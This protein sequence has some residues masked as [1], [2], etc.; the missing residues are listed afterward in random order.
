MA[1]GVK[2]LTIKEG[3]IDFSRFQDSLI[4]SL[5]SQINSEQLNIQREK[6]KAALKRMK[7]E[8]EYHSG[9]ARTRGYEPTGRKHE[10]IINKEEAE[11]VKEIFKLYNSGWTLSDVTQHINEK[12]AHLF[13]K[14]CHRQIFRRII[15]NPAYC[16]YMLNSDGELIKCKPLQG[17]EIITLDEWMTAQRKI[18]VNRVYKSRPKSRWLPLSPLLFCGVCGSKISVHGG[19]EGS[20]PFYGYFRHLRDGGKPCQ[21]NLT[22]SNDVQ[23]GIGINEAIKPLLLAEA[24]HLMKAAKNESAER[25]KL[26]EVELALNEI[27]KKSKKLT[28]MWMNSL[29]NED[30][31]ESAIKDLKQRENELSRKQR[32]LELEL[33]QDT[34]QFDWAKL[35]MKF[36]GDALT[37]GEYEALTNRMIKKILVYQDHLEV[38]TIYGDV[39]IPRQHVGRYRLVCN[40]A[41]EM[42]NGKAAVYFYKGKAI[43]HSKDVLYSRTAI[44]NEV[45]IFI[46]E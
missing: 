17:K 28:E 29:M 24:L 6:V 36:R 35:M 43:H 31:Y 37:N 14:P 13:I 41:L 26:A 15:L 18:D 10:V 30:V 20:H 16:G 39:E 46:E 19:Q 22:V 3:I 33:N 38:K 44:L 8:G 1:H 23:E 45:D 11:M 9:I 5:T 25:A 42:K 40:Y 21:I 27:A 4:S 12:Y 7:N 32:A 2:L 34:S